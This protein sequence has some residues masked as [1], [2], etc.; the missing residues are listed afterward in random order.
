MNL[1]KLG[2]MA[3]HRQ[4]PRKVRLP[5]YIEALYFKRFTREWPDNVRSIEQVMMD[6]VQKQA[7]RKE[8]RRQQREAAHRENADDGGEK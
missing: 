3:N 1:K 7:E 6:R 5:Q 2:R 8:R 4:E